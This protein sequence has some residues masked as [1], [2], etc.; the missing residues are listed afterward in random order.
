MPSSLENPGSLGPYNAYFSDGKTAASTPVVVNL[1]LSALTYRVMNSVPIQQWSYERL[2]SIG[3]ITPGDECQVGSRDH[4]GAILF[5]ENPNFATALLHHAPHLT[6]RAHHSRLLIPMLLIAGLIAAAIA[7]LWIFDI[8]PARSLAG[9]MPD[10]LRQGLGEQIIQS[11]TKNKQACNSKEGDAALQKLL[12]RLKT[13]TNG[14]QGFQVRV[15]KIGIINAF[16]APGERIVI[17]DKLLTFVKSP[18]ELAG[19]IAHE[20]G[21]G[22]ELHPETGIIR[23]LG[24]SAGIQLILG[25]NG[26]QLGEIGAF[27]LQLQYTR[28]AERQADDHAINILRDANIRPRPF[29]EFFARLQK[30]FKISRKDK[31][32]DD[33]DN[34]KAK[35]GTE[36]TTAETINQA[37]RLLSTHPPLPQRAAKIASLKP[38]PSTPIL[39]DVEWSALRNIC[40]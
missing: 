1:T 33:S 40:D 10:K 20:M 35:K 5:I 36:S 25:G 26:G 2:I 38:W 29:S 30:R 4:P 6:A 17:S 27:L 13:G 7:A 12:N 18:E 24:I 28:Q 14:H 3:H 34:N 19:V 16:A 31:D 22:L 32:D 23:A 37:L 9:T 21:H 15:A 39:T 8:S 11:L